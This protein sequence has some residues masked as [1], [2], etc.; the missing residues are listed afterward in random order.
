MIELDTPDFFGHCIFCDDIRL[1][2]GGKLIYLGVYPTHIFVQ[3]GFPFLFQKLVVSISYSQIPE[4]FLP[5]KFWLFL[6]GDSEDKASIEAVM[7]D[8]SARGALAAVE[9]SILPAP[10]DQIY[11]NVQAN[12]TFINVPIRMP[13][14][15]KVRAVRDQELVKLGS[16]FIRPFESPQGVAPPAPQPTPP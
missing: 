16:I 3:G 8:E 11:A 5:P 14:L 1:E 12:F 10:K 15:I 13:G 2:V 9:N 7:P 4:K 6:P